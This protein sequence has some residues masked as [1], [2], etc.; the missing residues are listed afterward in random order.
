MNNPEKN[1]LQNEIEKLDFISSTIQLHKVEKHQSHQNCMLCGTQA[2]F[3]LSDAKMGLTP[4]TI[5]PYLIDAIGQ[6]AARRYF[7]T[8]ERFSAETAARLGLV[9]EVVEEERL[10]RLSFAVGLEVMLS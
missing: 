3:G 9:S 5:S 8:A 10:D 7:M 1:K 6:R 4:A 2:S